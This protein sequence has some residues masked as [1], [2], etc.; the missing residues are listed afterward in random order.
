MPA[1]YALAAYCSHAITK[2]NTNIGFGAHARIGRRQISPRECEA[3]ASSATRSSLRSGVTLAVGAEP[4]LVAIDLG[5]AGTRRADPPARRRATSKSSR[6]LA[7]ANRDG[8]DARREER[9]RI[10]GYAAMRAGGRAAPRRSVRSVPVPVPVPAPP[11]ARRLGGLLAASLARSG[12][13]RR[14]WEG[15]GKA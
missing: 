11:R 6:M 7:V 12:G 9:M 4:R 3:P 14:G 1:V 15:G 13:A 2:M 5:G 8:E 10:W